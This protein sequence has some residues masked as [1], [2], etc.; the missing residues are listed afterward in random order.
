MKKLSLLLLL[1]LTLPLRMMAQDKINVTVNLTTAGTL[2]EVLMDSEHDHIDGLTIKGKFNSVDLIY[3]QNR[4]GRLA[5]LEFL[6]LTDIEIVECD[7]Y[8]YY[9]TEPK[10]SIGGYGNPPAHL[11]YLSPTEY[12]TS[13]T[14]GSLASKQT[15]YYHHTP[16][17]DYAFYKNGGQYLKEICLPKGNKKVG[18][19]I[20]S[21]NRYLERVV[22]PE[23]CEEV[24][25]CAFQSCTALTDIV[26]TEKVHSVGDAAFSS[27]QIDA[28]FAPLKYIGRDYTFYDTSIKSISFAEELED[29]PDN[30]F[31]NCRKLEE[32]DIPGSVK[33]IGASAF[34]SCEGLT[35]VTIGEGTTTLGECAF[36][37]CVRASNFTIP[38]T[39]I[40]V[41]RFALDDVPL[42]FEMEE[43]VIYIGKVAYNVTS[44]TT[45]IVIREGTIAIR[46]DFGSANRVSYH[47]GAYWATSLKL[48]STLKSIGAYAFESAKLTS[49]SLPEGLEYIGERAFEENKQLS[50]ITIP[51]SLKTIV[52]YA[53]YNCSGL[54]R[55]NWNAINADAGSCFD[56]CDGIEQV[57]FGEGVKRVP[58]SFCNNLKGLVRIQFSSTIEEIGSS[59]FH[60]C[61]ALKTIIWPEVSS[62]KKLGINCFSGCKSLTAITL[63]KSV[64]VIDKYV[65]KD[66]GLETLTL[67][68]SSQLKEIGDDAF[69]ELTTLKSI[70]LEASTAPEGITIGYETFA[71]CTALTSISLANVK[72]VGRESFERCKNL[73][74][75][76]IPSSAPLEEIG[77]S[78]FSGCNALAAIN[79][80]DGIKKIGPYSFYDTSITTVVLP[81]GL[82]SVETFL[83]N[84]YANLK[85]AYVLFKDAEVLKGIYNSYHSKAVLHVPYGTKDQFWSL[86]DVKTNFGS[87]VEFGAPSESEPIEENTNVDLSKLAG[88]DLSNAVVD[89]IYYAVETDN[90]D[91]Y[92]ATEGCLVLNSTMT[93]EEMEQIFESN[94]NDQSLVT[95]YKGMVLQLTAGEGRIAIDGQTAGTSQLMVKIGD[96]EPVALEMATRDK[97]EIA[98]QL[99]ANARAYI[100]AAT[101]TAATSRAAAAENSVKFYGVSVLL[102][103]E[104]TGIR[105]INNQNASNEPSAVYNLQGN[106]VRT[107]STM[108]NGLTP[109][110]YITKGKKVVVY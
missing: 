51:S 11:Y 68:E 86:N 103:K 95:N 107:N 27:T 16:N 38:S 91:G 43:G 104:E 52:Y 58:D 17:L 56:I 102:G 23:N 28:K 98:Y 55:I 14:T 20:C 77:E 24:G 63:P 3:L 88:E 67:A 83:T 1:V 30:A 105:T 57:V 99:D 59:A 85:D 109:G 70:N 21:G 60:S 39:V 12:T 92:D 32:L 87:C 79:F 6:D 18:E 33:T 90:G 110:L 4:T 26:N 31:R 22:L 101:T 89:G 73:A 36:A 54:L 72:I 41:G 94:G 19:Y 47:S 7:E 9:W 46:E 66:S 108:L 15:R 74:E 37:G 100:Y 75:V 69:S 42:D 78:A 65:F 44:T 84:R 81:A 106:K 5:D 48:P 29:I 82:E 93:A 97:K 10:S 50:S 61:T 8:Y 49:L 62:L 53:F 2:Q 71:G 40:S 76:K 80:P 45:D 13:E 34:E 25:N 96:A 35:R 64:E